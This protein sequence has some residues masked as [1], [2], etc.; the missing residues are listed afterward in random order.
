M[1]TACPALWGALWGFTQA[2]GVA[3]GA[4]AGEAPRGGW[5][6]PWW[7]VVLGLAGCVGL[8]DGRC[9][10]EEVVR[11]RLP[12]GAYSVGLGYDVRSYGA[13]AALEI[14]FVGGSGYWLESTDTDGG[15]RWDGQ[16]IDAQRLWLVQQVNTA[17]GPGVVEARECTRVLDGLDVLDCGELAAEA[18]A[19]CTP[20]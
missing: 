2:G 6:M 20:P 19:W 13:S 11:E 8:D 16:V 3:L 14:W 7:L 1:H 17:D 5:R 9:E 18:E 15:V 12:E 10:I 4:D